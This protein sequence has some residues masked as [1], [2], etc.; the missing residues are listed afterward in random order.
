MTAELPAKAASAREQFR[1][2][3]LLQQQHSQHQAAVLQL[4]QEQG[5]AEGH[6]RQKTEAAREAA[7]A[8]AAIAAAVAV[9]RSREPSRPKTG[10]STPAA[11]VATLLHQHSNRQ[12]L[13]PSATAS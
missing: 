3:Q 1:Q 2:Q 7:G 11:G 9:S 6:A 10:E 13:V 5:A 8:A 4:L 12:L